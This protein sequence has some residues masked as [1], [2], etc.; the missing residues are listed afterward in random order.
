[1]TWEKN[2]DSYSVLIEEKLKDYFVEIKERALDYHPFMAKVYS[3]LE[4]F[5]LR[6]GK[7]LASYST[8]LTYQGYAG[9]VD[10]SILNVCI[11]IELYRH[12]ILVH[13]D[14]VDRDNL[15]RGERTL[16]KVFVEDH[17]DRFGEGTAIFVGN[18]A[19]ALATQAIIDSGFSPEKV[20]KLLLLLSKGYEE[21][22]ESQILDLLFE[23]KDV[24]VDEWRIMASK[25]AASLF[26]VTMLIGAVLGGASESNQQILEEAA[27]NIG[28]S[29]DI[30]DDIIDTFA[31]EKEYGRLPCKDIASGKKPL[32][33]VYTLN[34]ADRERAKTLRNFIGKKNLSQK[35]IDVIRALIEES[36]ALDAAKKISREHA[37]KAKVL[38]YK[39]SLSDN[40]KEFFNSFISYMEQS[41]DWYK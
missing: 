7:R 12:C 22:N 30:Q 17:D 39:T 35:D 10:S 19:Y 15:R 3:D 21:V 33:V 16:H 29:F 31:Q 5:V 34:S 37:E 13:D 23:Y 24:D 6:K 8:L 40:A 20:A 2:L 36:G 32:H 26:K 4:A 18:I 27:V 1:M 11:G 41:L 28:Y 9:E 14:L 25:R 38:I